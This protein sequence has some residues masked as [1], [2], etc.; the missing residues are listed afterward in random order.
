M[1]TDELLRI[2]QHVSNWCGAMGYPNSDITH[3]KDMFVGNKLFVTWQFGIRV[4]VLSATNKARHILKTHFWYFGS[5][6]TIILSVFL[7]L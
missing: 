4:R 6:L 3:M 7:Y 2:E 5:L 1:S